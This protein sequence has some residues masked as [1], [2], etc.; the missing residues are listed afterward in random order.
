MSNILS[1]HLKKDVI[2]LGRIGGQYAK[3]RS[4]NFEVIENGIYCLKQKL[5]LFIGEIL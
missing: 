4:N 2:T 1:Y 3:P 5:F